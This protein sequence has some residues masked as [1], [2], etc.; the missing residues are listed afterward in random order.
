MKQLIRMFGVVI[1]AMLVGGT[2]WAG[3]DGVG[4]P[5]A[6]EAEWTIIFYLAADNDQEAYA[7]STI[8]Q[9]LAG[10]ANT[11]NHLQVL[12][13]IDRLSVSG[14]EVFEVAGGV[15]KP[16]A[17]HDEQNT[18]DGA[19]LEKFAVDALNRAM[20][21]KV[22]FVM[23]SEGFSWR[24]IGR[25]NTHAD[26]IDDQLMSN[27]ALAEALINAQSTTGKDLDLLVLEGSIMAF[28]EVVYELRDVA[29]LLIAS[30]SKIQFDGLPW[31]M[32]I[33]DLGAN[34]DMTS[35]D[36]GIDIIDNH[37][38]YYS[39]K[40]NNGV[41]KNDTSI[42][43]A[44]LTLYDMPKIYDV[45]RAH[46]EWAKITWNHFDDV[47]NILPHA[48]DLSEV[49][50]FGEITEFDYNFDLKTFM[51]EGLR[52][53]DEAGLDFPDLTAAVEFYLAEQQEFILYDRSPDD[54][55]K[56]KA[57]NGLSIWYPPTW[58]KYETFNESDEVFGSTMYYED[59]E[60][61]LDWVEDSNWREYLFEYFD[62]ADAKLVGKDWEEPPK[63]GQ[64]GS[65]HDH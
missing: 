55:F 14:T 36:L 42:N 6:T 57:T 51:D 59:P 58:N 25:D 1:L 31:E 18:A 24:G 19:V 37:L 9:L 43:F 16:L 7:D 40:G 63:R 50:G 39:D 10:T 32:V 33:E 21:D 47:Y 61:G 3:N 28:I 34:P 45:L 60:I 46:N 52:L 13:M 48:R 12:V 41:P 54:G 17:I 5:E 35:E 44:A 20:H 2:S 38:A 23:K 56:L 30:Q 11:A 29:P 26:D 53:I 62:R 22:A 8:N 27:G 49:G 15:K 65:D 64:M 4:D